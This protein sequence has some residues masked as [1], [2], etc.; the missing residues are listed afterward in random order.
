MTLAARTS[1]DLKLLNDA[2]LAARVPYKQLA[3]IQRARRELSDLLRELTPDE[4]TE[5]GSTA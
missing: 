1:T 4:R 3:K 2:A 5:A